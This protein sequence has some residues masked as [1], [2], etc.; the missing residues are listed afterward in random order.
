MIPSH[1]EKWAITRKDVVFTLRLC[2][3]RI[4]SRQVLQCCS[5]DAV[6]AKNQKKSRNENAK[7][8]IVDSAYG[9]LRIYI[10][11]L[12]EGIISQSLDFSIFTAQTFVSGIFATGSRAAFVR[13]FVGVSA[14]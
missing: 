12:L 14:K 3:C 8:K 7:C 2:L 1:H 6:E 11:F 4:L 5:S 13:T 9:K 10:L